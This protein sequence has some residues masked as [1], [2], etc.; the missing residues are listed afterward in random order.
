MPEDPIA[1][2]NKDIASKVFMESFG[3]KSLKV[4]GLDLPRVKCLLPTNL[5]AI[6]ANELRLDNLLLLED[7]SIAIL[8]YESIYSAADMIKYAKYL[9]RV[10]DRYVKDRKPIPTL[11]FIVIYT[12]D[13]RPEQVSPVLDRNGLRVRIEPAFLS[14]LDS[15]AIRANLT[16]KVERG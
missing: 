3:Q 5:P 9:V 15:E 12:A 11:R 10:A 7:D 16:A 1:Y 4:Y 6:E 13:I 8:D 14:K 2:Q